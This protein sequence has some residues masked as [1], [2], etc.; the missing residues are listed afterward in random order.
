MI[1]QQ[2]NT[3]YREAIEQQALLMEFYKSEE[4][5]DYPEKSRIKIFSELKKLELLIETLTPFVYSDKTPVKHYN[6]FG[7]L[8]YEFPS[9]KYAS[10]F[11]GI[12]SRYIYESLEGVKPIIEKTFFLFS[13]SLKNE[14]LIQLP[15]VKIR[16]K[17]GRKP[18]KWKG[19]KYFP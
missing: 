3:I 2:T 15:W 10:Y 5:F 8:L 6:I 11:T 18:K 1:I 4:I 19:N 7:D 16:K 9:I 17:I 14:H 12:E 13:D